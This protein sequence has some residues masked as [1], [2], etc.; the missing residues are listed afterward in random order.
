MITIGI[1]ILTSHHQANIFLKKERSKPKRKGKRK[2][3]SRK[4]KEKETENQLKEKKENQTKLGSWP[5]VQAL[6]V[7]SHDE[8][9]NMFLEPH[10]QANIFL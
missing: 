8:H 4:R 9:M 10:H 1:M 5:S 6:K 7:S 2:D 3:K